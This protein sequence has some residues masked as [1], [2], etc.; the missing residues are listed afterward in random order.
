MT[1]TALLVWEI[2]EG[3]GHVPTLK[4]IGAGLQ[5]RGW[6]TVFALREIEATRASLASLDVRI[7][8]APHFP[9]AVAVKNPSFTYADIL[10]A[11][12]FGTFT[13]LRKLIG[14]WDL[15]FSEVKPDLLIAEHSPSALAAAFGRV[16]AA[17]VGNGFLMPPVH[18]REFPSYGRPEH[19]AISQAAML[20]VLKEALAGRG[21]EPDSI[22][23]PFRGVFRGV[24]SFPNLDP[25]RAI[26]SEPAMGPIETMP[27]LTALP[28]RRNL[29]V[30]SAGDYALIDE[31]SAVMMEL[32]PK[33]SAYF[34]GTLGVR[35]AVLK[36]RGVTVFSAA[37]ALADI[38][39]TASA[40][41]SHAGSGFASAALAAGR[42]QILNPR[43]GEAHMTAKLLED[44]GVA[45]SIETLERGRLR[46]AVE[47]M[48]TDKQFAAKAQQAGE[49]AQAFLARANALERTIDALM[50]GV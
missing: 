4:A 32:G 38:L 20:G 7:L 5:A 1:K 35:A 43:H 2:G 8:Q 22:T 15:I 13:D 16:P 36:S 45:I 37:P 49:A 31:L 33:A 28:Q 9:N 21:R 19:G 3:L 18:D 23:A 25:Y 42:P 44:M 30:Y 39:P 12:G 29:F 17:V 24:Y 10:A 11:N 26:R 27:P 6:R 50:S 47:R 46:E 40:V 34:R 41:F 48:H 14:A